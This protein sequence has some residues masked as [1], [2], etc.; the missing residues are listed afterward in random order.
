MK[1]EVKPKS[2]L[3]LNGALE[4]IQEDNPSESGNSMN[5]TKKDR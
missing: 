4:L 3:N 1:M 2:R 5:E